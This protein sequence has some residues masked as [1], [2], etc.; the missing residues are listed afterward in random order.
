VA[1]LQEYIKAKYLN[2]STH[3]SKKNSFSSP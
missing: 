1:L 3:T 2:T